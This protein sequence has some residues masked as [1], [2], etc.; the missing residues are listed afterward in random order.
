MRRRAFASS[1][2]SACAFNITSSCASRIRRSTASS[3]AHG[4]PRAASTC[5]RASSTLMGARSETGASSPAPQAHVSRCAG[6]TPPPTGHRAHSCRPAG[7]TPLPVRVRPASLLDG[8]GPSPRRTHAVPS[9]RSCVLAPE[10][11]LPRCPIQRCA[12]ADLS[13]DPP[14]TYETAAKPRPR[15]HVP[16]PRVETTSCRASLHAP[17]IR[18]PSPAC[19]IEISPASR[20]QLLAR[21]ILSAK[22]GGLFLHSPPGP[23]RYGCNLPPER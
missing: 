3:M 19:L 23:P 6:R 10:H 17:S 12:G 9:R 14:F 21:S 8:R 20:Q 11:E 2:S 18:P 16:C 15:H 7:H 4:A 13:D 1:G 22:P 5:L